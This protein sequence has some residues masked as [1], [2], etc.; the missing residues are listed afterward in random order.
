MDN[1]WSEEVARGLSKLD[2]LVYQSR[3]VGADSGLV[4][5]GG[6]NTSLK[7][8][9]TDFRGRETK[10]LLI[11]ASGSD[12]K[13]AQRQDFP[14][15]RLDDIL[16]LFDRADMADE[17]LVAYLDHCLL[18]PGS[19]RPSIE[20]LLHAFLP[21]ASV[22]H[23]HADAILSMT[24]TRSPQDV[25][26]QVYGSDVA[27]VPY[28]RPGFRL[29][30]AV[31]EA[32][33]KRPS[34]KGVVLLN[35]GLV[36]WGTTPK[37]SYHTHIELVTQAEEFIRP[38][39][40]GKVLF[41]GTRVFPMEAEERRRVAAA[42]T[43]GLR[44]AL[45]SPGGERVLLQFDDCGEVLDFVGSKQAQELAATGP[46]TPD[47]LLHTKRTP[48]V[49]EVSDPSHVGDLGCAL[50]EG[51]NNYRKAYVEWFRR[52]AEG[53]TE[54]LDSSPRVVLVPGL[55][56]WVTGQDVTALSVVS[57]VYHHTI[58]VM[59]G[60]QAVGEYA[61]LSLQDAFDA[62]YWPQELYKLTLAHPEKELSR[63]VALVTGGA[64]GIGRAIALRLAAEGAHLVVTDVDPEGAQV[65]AEEINI[66]FGA[67]RAVAFAMDVASESGVTQAFDQVR[68]AYGGLDILVSNAGVA[69][70]GAIHEL[71]LAD[72]Q[73]ALDINA[74]G[75][76]LVAREAVKLMRQQGLGGSLVFIA[77]KNVTAPGK[78]F[79]AYSAS[80]AAEAQLA[81]VL[82]IENGEYGIRCNIV[83]PDAIFRG[84][85]LWSQQVRE[86]RAQAHGIPVD[87]LEDHY[88][89]RNL[90][91]KSILAEDV[92]EAVLFLASD[93]SSKITG[94]MLPVDGGLRE[95]FPR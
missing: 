13:V 4:I 56:M 61:S 69:P 41:G 84:S 82:A 19:P 50:E 73:R 43:P 67:G 49:V 31:A 36:T 87:E 27:V 64:G 40:S 53:T 37:A 60:A 9:E 5:W 10:L 8:T 30:K 23:S 20:T 52:H 45:T 89:Q 81:R 71:P 21:Q 95:A 14:A 38:Q 58:N 72:W 59:G 26:T 18:E 76:F 65:V 7:V 32:A 22:V 83:N 42:V 68:L 24:N 88:R 11:K 29:S 17:D 1:R 16:T 34:V 63:R 93:R 62:E 39:G 12:M 54:M 75:H 44:S 3:L 90:L 46:V 51:V 2:L 57:E 74:T 33:L 25:L 79:G 47:H 35:H 94:A 6:G 28:Q 48:L 55:G 91:K 15:L 77:T 85:G 86:Q 78:D 92:A 80:K 70:V 66:D